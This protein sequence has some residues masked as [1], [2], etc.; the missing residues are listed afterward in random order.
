MHIV[1]LYITFLKQVARDII[2][3]TIIAITPAM[4]LNNVAQNEIV[5][6]IIMNLISVNLTVS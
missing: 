5:S 2:K 6:L 1:R 4:G 3:A